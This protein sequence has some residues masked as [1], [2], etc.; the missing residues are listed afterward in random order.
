MHQYQYSYL[1]LVQSLHLHQYQYSCLHIQSLTCISIDIS[2]YIQFKIQPLPQLITTAYAQSIASAS[3]YT[4]I[5]YI[6]LSQLF[7]FR[8]QSLHH[9]IATAYIYSFA[10]TLISLQLFI[11]RVSPIAQLITTVYIQSIASASAYHT[12]YIQS[13]VF[14]LVCH[15]CYIHNITFVST[16]HKYL[17]IQRIT[18]ASTLSQP[19]IFS[20]ALATLQLLIFNSELRLCINFITVTYIQNLVYI[21][22]CTH[23]MNIYI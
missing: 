19:L 18:S 9:L 17:Y 12:T 14:A 7:I 4:S 10:F 11:F 16:Y 20:S 1:Y 15:S 22:K 3:F 23:Y 5:L 8:A 13:I 21:Q 2:I 6:I